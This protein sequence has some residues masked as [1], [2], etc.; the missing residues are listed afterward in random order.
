MTNKSINKWKVAKL[1]AMR[2]DY[3]KFRADGIP[4]VPVVINQD[5]YLVEY[6][7]LLNAKA[8][9]LGLIDGLRVEYQQFRADG[10]GIV[11][12]IVADGNVA[13]YVALRVIRPLKH[14]FLINIEKG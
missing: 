4:D 2:A 10:N 13:E 12:D 11:P 8:V 1:P 6:E 3:E 14:L 9:A 5:D 7:A